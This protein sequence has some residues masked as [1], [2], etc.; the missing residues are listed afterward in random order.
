MTVS[1][2]TRTSTTSTD[3]GWIAD[4]HDWCR[5]RL[6]DVTSEHGIAAL[7]DAV[8]LDEQPQPIPEVP[9]VWSAAAG[10]AVGKH[11]PETYRLAVGQSA[12]FGDRLVKVAAW[13]SR[14]AVRVFDPATSARR[15]LVGIDTFPPDERWRLPGRFE[16]APPE[17]T[18]PIQHH[19]V[20][21]S[22]DPVAG[23]VRLD[24]EGHEVAL[25]AFPASEGRLQVSF[26][27]RTN[28]H[29]TAQFRFLSVRE[30]DRDGSTVVDLNRAYLPPCAFSDHYLCPLPPAQNRLPFEVRAGE[31]FIRRG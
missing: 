3:A 20:G 23:V 18:R 21:S 19:G 30:P 31:T 6:A 12:P 16:P 9:G 4:W 2:P 25:L 26:A 17:S 5:R 8:W 7:A 27:D 15:S 29:T 14:L 13:R 28:G 10:Q 24:L 1:T 22:D 11:G